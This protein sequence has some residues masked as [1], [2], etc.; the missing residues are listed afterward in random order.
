[1]PYLNETLTRDSVRRGR[2]TMSY[3]SSCK[4]VY[5]RPIMDDCGPGV[6][7]LSP[8]TRGSDSANFLPSPWHFDIPKRTTRS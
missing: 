6:L 3:I 4:P 8:V 5:G 1:M 2:K 7:W